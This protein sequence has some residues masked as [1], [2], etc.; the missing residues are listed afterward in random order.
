MAATVNI[1]RDVRDSFYRYKMPVLLTKIEGKGNGI[2]TVFPNM[3]DVARALNRPAS[4][5]TKYFGCE[6]GAQATFNDDTERYIVNGAHDQNRMRE[7]LDGFIDRFVLCQSCKNPE[8]ELLVSRDGYIT[9]DCKACGY[10]G[11]ID[12]RHKLTT[13]ISKN[14]PKKAGKKGKKGAAGADSIAGQPGQVDGVE[15]EDND[16]DELT[17]KIR[18]GAEKVMTEEEAARLIAEREKADDWAEEDTSPEAMARRMAALG[19]SADSSLL[20]GDGDD[21]DEAAGPYGE[22]AAWVSEQKGQDAN[23]LS[24]AEL[25]KEADARGVT[26]KPHRLLPVLFPALFDEKVNAELPKYLPVLAKLNTSEKTVKALGGGIEKLVEAYP[27]TIKAVPKILMTLY[28]ADVMD[29][30]AIRHFATHVSKKYVSKDL[31]KKVRKAA[32]PILQW[33]DEADSEEEDEESE[34]E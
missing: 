6:L 10:H 30:D 24:A 2:K 29:E 9:A 22:F 13:F 7:L 25:Y 31:S 8:T 11:D 21:D 12:M 33:L 20:A 14:P 34:S 16:D 28:Q 32:D 5:P 15:D 23:G 4:Y 18:E 19:V 1:R 27:D 3:A 17:R 26:K